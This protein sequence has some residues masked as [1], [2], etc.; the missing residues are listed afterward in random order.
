MAILPEDVRRLELRYR[1]VLDLVVP[2]WRDDPSLIDTPGRVA[3]WW[4]EFL[5]YDPG[6][7]DT[8]FAAAQADQMVTV[9]GIDVWSL[10]EHHLLPFSSTITIG[11]IAADQVVG[12][13]KMARIAHKHAHALQLQERLV[14]QIAAD[15]ARLLGHDNVAVLADGRHLCQEMRGIKT[16]ATMHT[17]VLRGAFRQP[18]TREEFMALV[19]RA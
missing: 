17:S 9:S 18:A 15:L 3:R 6:N 8:L 5:N 7:T 13:S 2:G 19:G 16:P 14:A 10:C 12:L 11:Y 4:A 1:D